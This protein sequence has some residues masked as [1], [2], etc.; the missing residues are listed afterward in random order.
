MVD[1]TSPAVDETAEASPLPG[2][3]VMAGKQLLGVYPTREDAEAYTA[4]HPGAAGIKTTI[5]EQ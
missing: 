2:F 1:E 5:V 3:A 4:G